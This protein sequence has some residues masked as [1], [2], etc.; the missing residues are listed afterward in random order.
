MEVKRQGG[1]GLDIGD[2][3][4]GSCG[5]VRS[6]SPTILDLGDW[7]VIRESGVLVHIQLCFHMGKFYLWRFCT[8]RGVSR[9]RYKT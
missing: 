7:V 6:E 3:E 2:C 9:N 5:G 1:S 8:D 4:L